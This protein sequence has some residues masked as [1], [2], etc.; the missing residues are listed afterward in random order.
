ML[1]NDGP[2]EGS[3]ANPAPDKSS[4][5]ARGKKRPR[6]PKSEST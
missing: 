5:D 4:S 1:K 6:T 2:A 3:P